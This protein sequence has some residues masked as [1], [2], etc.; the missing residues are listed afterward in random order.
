MV[1]VRDLC[2]TALPA[3]VVTVARGNGERLGDAGVLSLDHAATLLPLPNNV[4]RA[5]LS[6]QGLVVEI[7]G[8]AT[9]DWGE[10]REAH[11]RLADR[12]PMR[13]RHS[14]PCAPELAEACVAGSRM[15]LWINL[16]GEQRGP[17]LRFAVEGSS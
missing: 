1:L 12:R 16:F 3:Q 10:V 7:A 11:R 15:Q 2:Q 9:I 8:R 4:A 13:I 17:I 14:A 5:W 6:E